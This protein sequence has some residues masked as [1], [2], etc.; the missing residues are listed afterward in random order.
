MESKL[1]VPGPRYQA[2]IELLKTSESLWTASRLFFARWE[3]SAS[4]FNV[5]NLLQDHPEGCSQVE[6]SRLLIMHRSNLTG[7]LDRM[8]D[9]NLVRRTDHPED[10]RIFNVKLTPEGRKLLQKILPHYYRAAESLWGDI[11]ADRVNQ[12]VR[13]MQ[14]LSQSTEAFGKSIDTKEV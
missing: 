1:S 3:I 5:L 2:L 8:E 7:L 13:E 6:L 9:R 10:R 14:K 11:S 12:L 4:Q